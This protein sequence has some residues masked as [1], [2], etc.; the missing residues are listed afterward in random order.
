MHDLVRGLAALEA[1]LEPLADESGQAVA[2]A[3]IVTIAMF[4][5]L[6]YVMG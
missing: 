2:T 4:Q 6:Y 1:A 3:V 5:T